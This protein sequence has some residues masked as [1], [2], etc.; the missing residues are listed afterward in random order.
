MKKSLSNQ[1]DRATVLERLRQVRPDS[2]RQWGRMTPHQMIC[3]LN[4]SFKMA[5]GL[6]PADAIGNALQ[7][8]VIKWIALSAPL[9]WPK[10]FRTR[11]E[12]DQE[13]G[14]TRPVEFAADRQELETL[15]ARFTADKKDF[16]W[17]RHPIFGELTELEWMR[18]GYLHMDH[19]LRQFGV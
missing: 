7:R 12:A 16:S 2:A 13:Q 1:Q 19:H 8:T 10:G 4:D 9:P 5:M 6:R 17:A 15:V 18:W 14:G 3:H 11:P